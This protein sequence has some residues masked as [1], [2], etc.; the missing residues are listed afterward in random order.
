MAETEGHT[1][2]HGLML[3]RVTATG[4]LDGWEGPPSREALDAAHPLGGWVTH[5]LLPADP[6]KIV[7]ARSNVT[8][9][10]GNHRA[11]GHHPAHGPVIVVHHFKWRNGIET[12][13]RRRITHFASETWNETTP[14]VRHEAARFLNHLAQNNGRIDTTDPTLA[15]RPVTL[16]DHLPTWQD[17]ADQILTGWRPTHAETSPER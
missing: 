6:R 8:I 14:A 3:D 5:R 4:R 15:F 13:L 10:S 7:L 17:E 9:S 16:H 12:D 11:P 1:V 2:V